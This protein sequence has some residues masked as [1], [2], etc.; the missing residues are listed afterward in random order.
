MIWFTFHG[1]SSASVLMKPFLFV[2]Y[3]CEKII[4]YLELPFI[5]KMAAVQKPAL[6]G[7]GRA[8]VIFSQGKE[9]T[10]FSMQP[11]SIYSQGGFRLLV[12]I[13]RLNILTYTRLWWEY[14]F[15][16]SLLEKI[17]FFFK[18]SV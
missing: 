1:R 13:V 14:P 8:F 12:T 4:D 11:F 15:L 2:L 18:M 7:I 16:L 10:L 17:D 6:C 3:I 9:Y 5:K